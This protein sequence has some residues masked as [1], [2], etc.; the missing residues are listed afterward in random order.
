M[1]SVN[2]Y[3]YTYTPLWWSKTIYEELSILSVGLLQQCTPKLWAL[4]WVN[5]QQLSIFGGQTIINHHIHPLT[6]LP[7]LIENIDKCECFFINEQD[8]E[9]KF[10]ELLT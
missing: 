5:K 10:V 7:E 6:K 1:G 3:V 2:V 4:R 9:I 8:F